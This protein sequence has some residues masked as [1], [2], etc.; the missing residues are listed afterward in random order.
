M[1]LT[2]ATG[3]ND[4]PANDKSADRLRKTFTVTGPASYATG[5]TPF[6]PQDLGFGQSVHVVAGG[7]MRTSSG[8]A[9][10]RI[11]SLNN[12]S[13]AAPKLQWY[14]QAYAEIANGVDLSSFSGN[15]EFI[16]K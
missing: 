10:C 14:D 13:P 7:I 8:G 6:T 12:E 9:S 1:A 3:V 2:L 16:G 11:V 15:L 5:G 4:I